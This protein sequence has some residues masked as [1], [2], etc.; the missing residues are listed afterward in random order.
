MKQLKH[1]GMKKLE[2]LT[3]KLVILIS[4]M[5][6]Y[7]CQEDGMTLE[8]SD[9]KLIEAIQSADKQGVDVSALP[10]EAANT[11]D[12][13][14]TEDFASEALLAAALG[15][16]VEMRR[17]RGA[18]VGEQTQ[19]YFDLN[20]REL[21]AENDQMRGGKG[22]HGKGDPRKGNRRDCF[23][24]GFP[25][26]LILPDGTSVTLESNEGWEDV[27]AWYQANP[28]STSRP[29]FTFPLDITYD[30]VEYVTIT[31]EVEL[32]DAK[33]SCDNGREKC[34]EFVY[35]FSMT[36]PDGMAIT[37]ESDED[38]DDVKAWHDA[39]QDIHERGSIDYPVDITLNDGTT[40]TITSDDEMESATADCREGRVGRCFEIVFPFTLTM[41]DGSSITLESH[42]DKNLVDAWYDSNQDTDER[43][44]MVYPIDIILEDGTS[45]TIS[46]EEEFDAVKE[47]CGGERGGKGKGPR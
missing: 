17:E 29:T 47:E 27:K 4:L 25:I 12:E 19:T 22:P 28:D 23:D 40:V 8:M 16:E 39:N 38:W 1:T 34:F 9:A 37:L 42:D 41:P 6:V 32:H 33:D 14:Y 31:S 35:P 20:G 21:S 43:P 46:T 45:Q 5:I 3:T 11:I 26:T 30:G 44:S 13:I 2:L 24:F 15:Y 7:S 18:L 10:N 36:M